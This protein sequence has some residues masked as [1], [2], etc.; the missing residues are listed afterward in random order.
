MK[1]LERRGKMQ[2]ISI[3]VPIYNAEKE[4]QICIESIQRQTYK[5]LEIILVDDGSTDRS[6]IICQRYASQDKRIRVIKKENGGVSSARNIGIKEAT[7]KYIQFVDSDDYIELNCCQTLIEAMKK[8]KVELVI[9][10][11]IEHRK[12]KEKEIFYKEQVFH[13]MKEMGKDFGDIYCMNLF[14]IPWNK[15]FIREKIKNLFVEELSLGEDLLFNLSY[16]KGIQSVSIIKDVLYHYKIIESSLSRG[17]RENYMEL[18]LDLYDAV[19]DFC[20]KNF[21]IEYEKSKISSY[22]A[23]A[24]FRGAGTL[25]EDTHLGKKEKKLQLKQWLKNEKIIHIIKQAEC[26]TKQEKVSKGI[27]LLRNSTIYYWILKAKK[28][29]QG[30]LRKEREDENS[31][32]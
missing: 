3:I 26:E 6:N 29:L 12:E 9:C 30:W 18:S 8:N 22:F 14:N 20:D 15:L 13:S 32:C 5:E 23:L 31:N 11:C 10:G 28:S 17:F 4:L 16:M 1:K 7:G 21:G 27:V 19:E 24:F 25:V 2:K